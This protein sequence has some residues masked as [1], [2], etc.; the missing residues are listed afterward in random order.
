MRD[1]NGQRLAAVRER[2]G[3]LDCTYEGWKPATR[4]DTRYTVPRLDCT[5]EGWKLSQGSPLVSGVRAGWIA[6][7]RDGNTME[8]RNVMFNLFVM[9]YRIVALGTVSPFTL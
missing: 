6:P 4:L 3:G 7:M 9:G 1:G 5:Y 2:V 8:L